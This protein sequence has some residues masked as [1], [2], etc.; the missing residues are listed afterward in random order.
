MCVVLLFFSSTAIL[1]HLFLMYRRFYVDSRSTGR[2][3]KMLQLQLKLKLREPFFQRGPFPTTVFNVSNSF[4]QD[5]AIAVVNPWE[6]EGR[7]NSPAAPFDQ[8]ESAFAFVRFFFL[9]LISFWM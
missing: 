5:V 4:S 6:W 1:T 3:T 8:R 2:L 9:V 7:G